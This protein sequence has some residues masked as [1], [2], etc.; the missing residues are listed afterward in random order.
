MKEDAQENI[1]NL[2]QVNIKEIRQNN[3][4]K[5]IIH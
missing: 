4:Q 1:W 5:I 2:R 3:H